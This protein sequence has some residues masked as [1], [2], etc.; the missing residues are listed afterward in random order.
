MPVPK[1]FAT[2][3]FWKRGHVWLGLRWDDL[4]IALNFVC[5]NTGSETT[6]C[7]RIELLAQVIINYWI[8]FSE[9]RRI[10][11]R[12]DEKFPLFHRR[13]RGEGE[14]E[15]YGFVTIKFT[16]S[17]KALL[18]SYDPLPSRAV[19]FLN[20]PPP[21]LAMTDSSLRPPPSPLTIRSPTL[22]LR[23]QVMSSNP[24]GS[25]TIQ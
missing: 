8:F 11:D 20:S 2:D 13:E 3:N 10:R 4:V 14:G 6:Q 24:K 21:L 9:F 15:D 5:L 16:W 22:S 7:P 25:K 23:R 17:F 1:T 12:V 18:Y 19:N